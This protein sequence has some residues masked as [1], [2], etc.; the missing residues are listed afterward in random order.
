[1]KLK[2]VELHRKTGSLYV[3]HFKLHTPTHQLSHH[4]TSKTTNTTLKKTPINSDLFILHQPANKHT[5]TVS[6]MLAYGSVSR[7][8]VIKCTVSFEHVL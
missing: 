3:L 4:R 8:P 7:E 2:E 5:I 6:R 1:M